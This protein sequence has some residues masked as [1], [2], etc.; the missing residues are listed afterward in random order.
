MK[1][2]LLFAGQYREISENLFKKSL[3]TFVK[4]LDYDIYCFLWDE[5]GKSLAHK[6]KLPEICKNFSARPKVENLFQNFNLK[7]IESESYNVFLENMD[8]NYRKIYNSKSY[9]FGTINS[10]PQIYALSK[11]FNL[12]D[13]DLSMDHF[14]LYCIVLND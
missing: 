7:K 2:A 13:H 5:E 12:L 6:T 3:S 10:L 14:L 11:C 8:L 9:H 1:I 4:D